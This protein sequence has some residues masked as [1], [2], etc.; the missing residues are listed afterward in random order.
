MDWFIVAIRY[1]RCNGPFLSPYK[2]ATIVMF[3]L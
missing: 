1:Y 2:P 3:W